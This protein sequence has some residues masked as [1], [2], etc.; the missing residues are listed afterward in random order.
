MKEQSD[1]VSQSNII[2]TAGHAYEF[3]RQSSLPIKPHLTEI[4]IMVVLSSTYRLLIVPAKMPS[5]DQGV[6]LH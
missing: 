4:L 6:M 5:C 3:F 2:I 1:L